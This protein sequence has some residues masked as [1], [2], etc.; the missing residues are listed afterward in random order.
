MESTQ[1]E[2]KALDVL[3]SDPDLYSESRRPERVKTLAQHGE[4]TKKHG[5]LE[6]S[7]L[8]LQSELEAIIESTSVSID[9]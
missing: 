7:W 6:E 1:A 8:E 5:Q 3:I 4:L 9:H 2:L